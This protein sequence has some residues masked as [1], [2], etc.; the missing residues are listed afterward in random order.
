[1]REWIDLRSDTVTQPNHEMR[2]AMELAPVGDDVFG[3]DPSVNR[4]QERVA[5]LLGKEAALFMPSGTMCNQVAINSHTQPGDEILCDA[6][7]H[8]LNYEAGGPARLSGVQVFPLQG[9]KGIIHADQVEQSIRSKNPHFPRTRLVEIENTHN[10]GG[11]K[12]FPLNE[13]VKI[14]KVVK[15]HQLALHLDGARLWNAHIASGVGLNE[16][17]RHC[18]SVSVCLSKGLGAPV[19]SVLAGDLEFIDRALFVRKVFGGGMRQAGILAAAG[20]Y[21]L[22]HNIQRLAEDHEHAKQLAC[23]LSERGAKVDLDSCETNIV[24][25]SL[26]DLPIDAQQFTERLKEKR[27]LVLPVTKQSV[28]FVTHLDITDEKLKAAKKALAECLDF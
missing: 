10:R 22:D 8:I 6:N 18:D 4:L 25:A 7:C 24:I 13:I 20:L 17:A 28:R 16:Y 23:L 21:A 27:V 12:L 9:E 2:K 3:E 5:E 1:M 11:G 15:K 26:N 19:G 14:S